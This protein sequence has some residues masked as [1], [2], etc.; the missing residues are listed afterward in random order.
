MR[1]S[2][3]TP[4]LGLALAGPAAAAPLVPEPHPL[5]TEVLAAVPGGAKGDANAD[6]VRDAI[7]DEFIELVNPHTRPINLKG[8]TLVDAEAYNPGAA[9]PA[10][11]SPTSPRPPRTG[12]R[13]PDG[14][15][16]A[17]TQPDPAAPGGKPG[18]SGGSGSAAGGPTPSRRGEVRFTFPD[19]ELKP[20]ELVVVFNGYKQQIAGAVGTS[21][22]APA[23]R[24][25]RFHEAWVFT[26][27]N[28]SPYAALGNEADMV[29]LIAP[30][31][32]P[33]QCI[34]W[35]KNDKNAPSTAP[36]I[37]EAPISK[38]S[39]QR[40]GVNG[41]LVAHPDLKGDL[42]GTLFSPGYFPL[43]SGG[44]EAPS[45]SPVE[46]PKGHPKTTRPAPPGK[47]APA[48]PAE[49]GSNP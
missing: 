4:V 48:A 30:D 35:G 34:R 24:H 44:S 20:G 46:S 39:V 1:Y 17:P 49:P 28:E 7:G 12:G 11:G 8:Y 23:R 33:V 3:L 14:S 27:A 10:G 42:A 36:L 31:G 26:M 41:K 22:K 32:S 38:G 21:T 15:K 2:T 29:V 6:G 9:T 45:G 40:E 37:E 5:I 25:E 18:A 16:P 19:L 47:P 43:N 13:G